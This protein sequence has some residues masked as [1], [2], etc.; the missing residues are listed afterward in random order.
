MLLSQPE[1]LI[2]LAR[3]DVFMRGE[4]QA[5][6]QG[7]VHSPPQSTWCLAAEPTP[8]GSFHGQEVLQSAG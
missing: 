2:P 6:T 4:E 5:S 8:T 7:R 3:W 1:E